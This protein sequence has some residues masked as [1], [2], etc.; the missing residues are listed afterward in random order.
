MGF[1]GSSAGK[2]STCNSRDPGLIPG[3]G[4]FPRPGHGNP[5]QYSCLENPHGQRSLV[6]YSPWRLKDLDLTKHKH[7][8]WV[9]VCMCVCFIYYILYNI[10]FLNKGKLQNEVDPE[11]TVRSIIKSKN[12]AY[13]QE[14]MF[15][16]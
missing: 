8:M 11:L 15:H 7:Y 3:L 4:K 5:L 9:C 2:D 10:L 13:L 12:L 16:L 1:P 14:H 6:G